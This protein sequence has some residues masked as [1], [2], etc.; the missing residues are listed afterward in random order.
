MNIVQ[1]LE[2]EGGHILLLFL[3]VILCLVL[4]Y[5]L[6]ANPLVDKLCEGFAGALLFAMKGNGNKNGD[7]DKADARTDLKA[8]IQDF[9]KGPQ[10]AATRQQDAGAPGAPAA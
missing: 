5:Q 1:Y 4:S 6:P 7:A 3:L 9:G 2:R 10:P 8:A